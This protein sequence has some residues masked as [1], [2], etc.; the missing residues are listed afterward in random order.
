M[1]RGLIAL[2]LF[3]SIYTSIFPDRAGS[4]NYSVQIIACTLKTNCHY[5]I[6]KVP[7]GLDSLI[8]LCFEPPYHKVRIGYYKSIRSAQAARMSLIQHGLWDAFIVKAGE[9]MEEPE[10]IPVP[11]VE[12]ETPVVSKEPPVSHRGINKLLLSS[13]IAIVV[14]GIIIIIAVRPRMRRRKSKEEPSDE[15]FKEEELGDEISEE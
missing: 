8:Y 12:V 2:I 1:R 13:V 15:E 6:V 10:Q 14:I 3:F 5:A 11:K 4:Q 9:T 7:P